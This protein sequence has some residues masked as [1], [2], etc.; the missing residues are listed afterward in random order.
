MHDASV[1]VADVQGVDLIIRKLVEVVVV[2]WGDVVIQHVHKLVPVRPLVLCQNPSAWPSTCAIHPT[3]S[4]HAW[5][6]HTLHVIS[7]IALAFLQ[8]L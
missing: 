5:F 2:G 1:I 8:V 3:S 4:R 6:M 7:S